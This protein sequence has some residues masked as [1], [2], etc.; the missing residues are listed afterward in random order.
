MKKIQLTHLKSK[1]RPHDLWNS[2][3]TTVLPYRGPLSCIHTYAKFSLIF[4]FWKNANFAAARYAMSVSFHLVLSLSLSSRCVRPN[5]SPKCLLSLF[6]SRVALLNPW[7]FKLSTVFILTS[8]TPF[9]KR[10]KLFYPELQDIFYKDDSIT[11][12]AVY[13][14]LRRVYA[15]IVAVE[16]QYVLIIL[17]VCL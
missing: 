9:H 14:I 8:P 17:S 2:T 10:Q 7:A 3:L 11:A 4:Y 6:H 12:Q 5:L 15:T 13:V 1:Q 16:K